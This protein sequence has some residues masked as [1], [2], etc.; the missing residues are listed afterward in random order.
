MADLA[1]ETKKLVIRTKAHLCRH[2]MTQQTP[3]GDMSAKKATSILTNS[4]S[5]ARK[6][7]KC[8]DG[9]REHVVFDGN[10]HTEQAQVYPK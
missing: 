7:D 5:I 9:T 3:D 6:L 1:D 10:N 8:C 2:A 4:S